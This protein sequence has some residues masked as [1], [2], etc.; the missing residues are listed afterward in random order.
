MR[1]GESLRPPL[2]SPERGAVAAPC[3][4]TEGLVQGGWGVPTLSDNPGRAGVEACAYD[5]W[6]G[7]CVE[8]VSSVK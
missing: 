1:K 4:V 3:A 5:V 8:P 6:E 2:G 7:G